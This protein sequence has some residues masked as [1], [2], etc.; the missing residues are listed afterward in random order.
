MHFAVISIQI[1][2]ILL[3]ITIG[4]WISYTNPNLPS[5]TGKLLLFQPPN[6]W[7]NTPYAHYWGGSSGN[8]SWP[9]SV[10]TNLN[11]SNIYYIDLNSTNGYTNIIFN[12]NSSPQTTTI[13]IPSS[14]NML[15]A[16][17]WSENN[18][19]TGSWS[20]ITMT[21]PSPSHTH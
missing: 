12:N 7:A 6:D 3:N 1:K 10:M 2:Q 4:T 18:L 15:Y 16:M 13:T 17:G 20:K 8:T 21:A 11:G 14:S 19:S 5:P 9:G